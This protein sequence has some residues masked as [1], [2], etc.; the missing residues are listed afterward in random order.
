M[1]LALI[2]IRSM[3][4][5]ANLNSR[6]VLA[7][8]SALAALGVALASLTCVC[9]TLAAVP[10]V[11]SPSA[12]APASA[13]P[14][15]ILSILNSIDGGLVESRY[16]HVTR[17]DSKRG[18]YE[19]DCSGMVDWVLRR[20][21]PAA[22]QSV[23]A[24]SA[25]GRLVARDF[26]R[27]IAAVSP[28]RATWSWERVARAADALPG[29]VIAWT[30]PPGWTT[31]IT[32]HVGFVLEAPVASR[33]VPGAVLVRVADASRYIHERDTREHSGRDGFGYGTILLTTDPETGA[34]FAYGW[35]GDRSAWVAETEI[36]IGR[37]RR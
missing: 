24:R 4:L 8:S 19:F 16:S 12:R 11:H 14:E 28:E 31:P 20:A 15:R 18:L 22:W 34:P 21:A 13:S 3:I 33:R 6:R 29:D 37:P 23:R 35:F 36:V 17:V 25:T 5:R 30:K 7:V 10:A 9:V 27:T 26:V 2:Q 1:P 32:G